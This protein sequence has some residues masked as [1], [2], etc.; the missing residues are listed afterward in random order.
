MSIDVFFKLCFINLIL[1]K[2]FSF[3]LTKFENPFNIYIIKILIFF[4]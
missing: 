1:K 4:R 2:F 3:F